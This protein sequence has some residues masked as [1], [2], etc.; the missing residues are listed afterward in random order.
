MLLHQD[1]G[2]DIT[3]LRYF[4]TEE[5]ADDATVPVLRDMGLPADGVGQFFNVLMDGA[6]RTACDSLLAAGTTPPYGDLVDE[7]HATC[8]RISHV[9]QV[10]ALPGKQRSAAE[11]P[12]ATYT[13]GAYREIAG[14]KLPRW[15]RASD[16]TSRALHRR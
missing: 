8:W 2:R 7:H 14:Q 13:P 1:T 5:A 12:D 6:G 16:E 3:T 9:R 15:R 11:L 10:A 4:S